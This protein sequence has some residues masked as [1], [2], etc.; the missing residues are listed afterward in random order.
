MKEVVTINGLTFILLAFCFHYGEK[1]L[2]IFNFRRQL[3]LHK[4]T[5]KFLKLTAIT[6]ISSFFGF[7]LPS[8]SGPDLIRIFNLRKYHSNYSEPVTATLML[9]LSNVFGAALLAIFGVCI[10]ILYNVNMRSEIIQGVFILSSLVIFIFLGVL[11]PKIRSNIKKYL[12]LRIL[13]FLGPINIFLK[14]LLS[15]I[16]RQIFAKN[17]IL[18]VVISI[19]GMI[20]SSI[21]TYFLSFAIGVDISMLYFIIFVPVVALLTSIPVSFAGIGIRESAFIALFS[22]VGVSS[23]Q[24]LTIGLLVSI[25]NISIAVLGGVIYMATS[26][27]FPMSNK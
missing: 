22:G 18:T 25:L 21:R 9:N 17:V 20:I 11:S 12:N 2:R 26:L 3:I 7:F 24:A 4:N 23:G 6:W 1:L 13:S 10:S 27:K 19:L 14:D 5:I 16:D 15:K 8:A